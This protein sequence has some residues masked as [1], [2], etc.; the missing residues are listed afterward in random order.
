[1]HYPVL[2]R[3]DSVQEAI[4]RMSLFSVI[5]YMIRNLFLGECLM[6]GTKDPA[7]HSCI[8]DACVQKRSRELAFLLKT[9]HVWNGQ[10]WLWQTSRKHGTMQRS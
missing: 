4:K 3:W 8:S 2:S 1:M 9:P 7:A 10:R 5:R 6:G